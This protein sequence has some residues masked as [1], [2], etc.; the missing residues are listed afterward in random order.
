MADHPPL[1]LDGCLSYISPRSLRPS[2]QTLEPSDPILSTPSILLSLHFL[3]LS[4]AS[5]SQQVLS[6][7]RPG[8]FSWLRL[9]PLRRL[10][11]LTLSS[12]LTTS[13]HDSTNI[14]SIIERSFLSTLSP[15]L[16]SRSL[17]NSLEVGVFFPSLT[18][19]E[20][21]PLEYNRHLR[22]LPQKPPTGLW[23]P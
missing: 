10:S 5:N 9:L 19:I 17:A 6:P 22:P 1:D 11:T 16:M 3:S 2:P 20:L 7:R 8:H 13:I 21:D 15:L 18:P 12:L 23:P 4:Q 14:V